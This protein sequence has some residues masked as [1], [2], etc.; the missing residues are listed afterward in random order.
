MLNSKLAKVLTVFSAL[1]L[2]MTVKAQ[3][4]VIG[5]FQGASDGNNGAYWQDASH[6]YNTFSSD[7]PYATFP[8]SVVPGYA[9]SLELNPE[10]AS[11]YTPQVQVVLTPAEITNFNND[12]YITF[13]FSVPTS[14]NDVQITGGYYQLANI[15]CQEGAGGGYGGYE[16]LIT[17]SALAGITQFEPTTAGDTTST[18]N[19]QNGD[20]N[21]Y[22]YSGAE[23]L[24]SEVVTINYSSFMTNA[25]I[26]GD[27]TNGLI[28]GFQFHQAEG[29]PMYLNNVELSPG[30]FGAASATSANVFVVDN[31]STNGVG[32][33]NPQNYDYFDS[34]TQE[35]YLVGDITNVWGN[36]FGSA[37]SNVVWNASSANNSP[38]NG[39]LQVNLDWTAGSQWVLHHVDYSQNLNVSSLTYTSMVMDVRWDASSVVATGSVGYANFGPLR[40]GVRASGANGTSSSGQ[41]WFYTTNIPAADTNWIHLVIPLAANDPN[42]VNWGELLVGADS[43]TTGSAFNGPATLYIDNIEFIGPLVTTIIPPPTV[44]LQPA[45]PG[46][47]MF[48]GSSANYIREGLITTAGSGESE[49]WVGSGVNYPVTY[50]FQLLS[51]PPANIGITELG[52][53][54]EAS[55]N[56]TSNFQTTIYGNSFLDYQVSN[57]L[58]LAIAPWNGNG[59]VTASVQWKV[60][61]PSANPTNIVLNIT[62]STAIGT[63]KLTMTSATQ[64]TL[65]A[66]G[67]QSGS[68][69]ISDPN[70]A[71]DFAN[72]AVAVFFEDPNSTAGYGL[73]EDWGTISITGTASGNQT[74][75]FSA[76]STDFNGATTSPGGF[77]QNNYSVD[78]ANLVISRNGLD[79][80]WVDWTQDINNNYFL[81]T[82]TNI[83]LPAANWFSP[84]FYAQYNDESAPRGVS[85]QH[86]AKWWEL[87]PSDDL[88]TAN[89]T[90][91]PGPVPAVTVPLAPNAYFMLTTN[92][93]NIYP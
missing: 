65:T 14:T 81:V 56:P 62:N 11:G 67:G 41:D 4:T 87:L 36:W 63:W 43:S 37:F 9:Y 53:L 83:L 59:P 47:R 8:T 86:G 40:F 39:C 54:P 44:N 48:V 82:S 3:T 1:A 66:P 93:A 52:I 29:S 6:G 30:P 12:S 89:G 23:S 2:A 42:Q 16:N 77:F 49:S 21:Y 25:D 71:S 38:S 79:K 26:V 78:P 20:P 73:Y 34:T 24:F 7:S 19:N 69:T 68:F 31:F 88:P 46:L 28:L 70:V 15:Y 17:A 74:E 90:A 76:E 72:P 57:G 35:V 58:Y 10:G 45:I 64:G 5:S 27:T 51:Y 85:V 60:G 75:N 13:T 84:L 91:Q 22:F 18:N 32:P 80:Y 33:N 50:S 55:F 61:M 92:T